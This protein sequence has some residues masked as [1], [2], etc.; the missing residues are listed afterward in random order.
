MTPTP[1]DARTAILTPLLDLL[2]SKRALV[3]L[4]TIVVSI[5]ILAVPS[6]D[7]LRG[8]LLTLVTALA[9][10]LIGGYT[11][12]D[13]AAA[14]KTSAA[15][16]TQDLK[17]VV[18]DAANQIINALAPAAIAAPVTEIADSTINSLVDALEARLLARGVIVPPLA[19]VAAPAQTMVTTP[20]SE[21]V[22]VTPPP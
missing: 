21:T 16:P 18:D 6:L 8:E 14:G 3:S 15:V 19:P 13:A 20:A 5:L 10:V 11:V 1:Y 9:L 17:T 4:A 12:S 7:S 2:K 22:T